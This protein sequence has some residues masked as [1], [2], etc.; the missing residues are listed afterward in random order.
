M[1][2]RVE[3]EGRHVGKCS[4]RSTVV[5]RS[6]RMTSIGYQNQ[7]MLIR[8]AAECIPIR[9]LTGIVDGDD[10]LGPWRYAPV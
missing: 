5:G 9:R 2:H 7:T 4:D 10:G 3:G 6:S 8:N 1:F